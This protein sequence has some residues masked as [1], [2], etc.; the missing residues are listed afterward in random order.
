VRSCH[1]YGIWEAAFLEKERAMGQNYLASGMDVAM[2]LWEEE[3][4]GAQKVPAQRDYE[5][6]GYVINGRAELHLEGQ[7]V[8]LEPGNFWIVPKGAVHTYSILEAFTAVEA[9]YS[10]AHVH[11]RGGG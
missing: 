6:V 9:T 8:V 5:T 1:G 2:R 4:P 10:P 7:T 11:G 3:P